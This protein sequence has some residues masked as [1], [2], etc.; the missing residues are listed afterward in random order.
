MSKLRQNVALSIGAM[1]ISMVAM[2]VSAA[3]NKGPVEVKAKN[4]YKFATKS[5][6]ARRDFVT[7][8]LFDDFAIQQEIPERYIVTFK[9]NTDPTTLS[10]QNS[11]SFGKSSSFGKTTPAPMMKN[12]K[13]MQGNAFSM[14]QRAGAKPHKSI[15]KKGMVSASMSKSVLNK[16]RKDPN[17]AS[18]SVD[19]RRRLMAETT[20]YGIPMVQG[21]LLS[22]N[23][24]SA[25]RVCVIDTGFNL[26]HP[27]LG[28]QN[29]GVTGNANNSRVGNWF[30]DGN[31]HGTHVAGTI[32]ALANNEG[33]VGVYPGV[34]IHVV[35]IF[36]DNGQ[37]TFSSD[38]IAAIQQC[39]DAGSNVVNMSLGGG[40]SS[41][42]ER[43]AMQSFVDD[44]IMLVAAA[45]NSGNTSLSYPASYDSVISVAAVDS[46]E[47]RASYSQYNSQVEI[48]GPGSAVRST[49]PTNT[50]NTISGTS[51]AT[52]HVAGAAALVW[53]FFPSCSNEQIRAALNITAKDKGSAGRDNLYGHGIVQARDAYDY[54]NA[55]GCDGNGGGSGGGGGGVEPFSGQLTNLSGAR[56][57]WRRYTWNVP[58]GIETLTVSI[59]GG[60]GDA[61]LYMKFGSQPET[62]SYDCR[63]YQNGNGET[64]T[65]NN[66]NSGTFHIGIRGYSAYSGVTMRYSY[67]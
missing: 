25:R 63:P 21:N 55:N 40:G 5:S 49:W 65:F 24:Q 32:S 29:N 67:E 23:D 56:N 38:I 4:P 37:W 9:E 41:T 2:S 64:C 43:N 58:S 16:L 50:Y 31:G 44:G 66:V 1:A 3:T 59:S 45:G 61:D 14:L 51:M 47:R 6:N 15:V 18:I 27:D 42:A 60:S 35:K 57:A 36:D 12:G 13:L 7:F 17:V 34:D 54:L 46:S 39:K 48:A 20:P 26:G 11:F 10:S 62:N 28:D 53:S 8:D 19:H 52:P 30:N 22:Q 33:V